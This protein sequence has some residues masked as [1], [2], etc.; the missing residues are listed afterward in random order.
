MEF[1]HSHA[2]PSISPGT[3]LGLQWK[4]DANRERHGKD[5]GEQGL[6][7]LRSE[8]KGLLSE[9]ICLFKRG[10]EGR[11]ICNAEFQA[12]GMCP[13]GRGWGMGWWVQGSQTLS[14]HAFSQ[15]RGEGL[16]HST[17]KVAPKVLGDLSPSK[18]SDWWVNRV[19]SN[20]LCGTAPLCWQR[21][22]MGWDGGLG[23][24]SPKQDQLSPPGPWRWLCLSLQLL[25]WVLQSWGRSQRVSLTSVGWR[26]QLRMGSFSLLTKWTVSQSVIAVCHGPPGSSG[27]EH[28]TSQPIPSQW[29]N[30]FRCWEIHKAD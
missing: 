21:A 10:R 26:E 28:T 1:Q 13:A 6:Q 16:L 15:S 30:S 18:A 2:K 9:A 23:S 19:E 12:P 20:W 8:T 7:G 22:G 3:L 5:V 4:L 11:S 24:V 14:E 25:L 17:A 27:I 29:G